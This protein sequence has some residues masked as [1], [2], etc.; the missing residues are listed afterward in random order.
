MHL[1]TDTMDQAK[2]GLYMQVLFV[3]DPESLILSIIIIIINMH[4]YIYTICTCMVRCPSSFFPTALHCMYVYPTNFHLTLTF[5]PYLFNLFVY[6][7]ISLF[8]SLLLL[9]LHL[10]PCPLFFF[11]FFFCWFTIE[12]LLCYIW[13]KLALSYSSSYHIYIR[14]YFIYIYAIPLDMHVCVCSSKASCKLTTYWMDP[15]QLPANIFSSIRVNL[16]I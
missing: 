16:S 11:F 7:I 14:V 3:E 2:C 15:V 8:L 12:P 5:V 10:R 13:G 9:F 4:S 6:F 1:S